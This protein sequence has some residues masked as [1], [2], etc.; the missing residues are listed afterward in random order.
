M[1]RLQHS[2]VRIADKAEFG[3]CYSAIVWPK[4]IDVIA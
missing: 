1:V 4:P 3:N 2:S